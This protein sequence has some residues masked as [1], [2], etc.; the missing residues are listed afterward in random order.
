MS[1]RPRVTYRSTVLGDSEAFFGDFDTWSTRLALEELLD[2]ALDLPEIAGGLKREELRAEEARQA[3]LASVSALAKVRMERERAQRAPGRPPSWDLALEEVGLLAGVGVLVAGYF[4]VLQ[5]AWPAMPLGFQAFGLLGLA[6]VIT[7]SAGR[8][9]RRFPV[10]FVRDKGRLAGTVPHPDLVALGD[11]RD[12]ALREI[13]LPE[14]RAYIQDHRRTFDSTDLTFAEPDPQDEEPGHDLV[15]TAAVRRLRRIVDRADSVAIALAGSRGAGKTTSIRSLEQG[16]LSQAGQAAPL[17]VVGSAPAAYEARDFVLHLHALLCKAVLAAIPPGRTRTADQVRWWTVL[18]R[19]AWRLLSHALK[20]CVAL[21]AVWLLWGGSV[22]QAASE[23]AAFGGDI[24]HGRLTPGQVWSGLPVRR[25]L[26]AGVL[27]AV[28]V[29]ESYGV[30]R[31]LLS[32]LLYLIARWGEAD[33]NRLQRITRQQLD[34]IR[35]LQTYTTGWSGKLSM[36]LRGEAGRTWSTQRAEQQLTHP[37]VVDKFREFAELA[38]ACLAAEDVAGR[39]V[40]A[41]DELDKIGEPE[42][43]HQFINDVKGVFDVPGC[44][45]FVSVSDDA[46]LGFEQRGLGVRDAFDSAF[47]EM[48][49]LE[50]FTLDESRLWVALRLRGISEQFCYLAHCLS[51]GLPR[52]LKRCA[53]E[54]VDL[55]NESYRPSLETVART[56]VTAE[57]AGKTRAF[58]ATAATLERSPELVALTTDLLGVP[59]TEAPGELAGLAARLVRADGEDTAAPISDLRWHSGCFVLFCAT[60]LEIF[61]DTLTGDRL[62]PGLH[63]LA[64]VRRRMAMHPRQAW[65]DLAEFRKERGLT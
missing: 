2:E 60:V 36:P 14:L 55:A 64:V 63:R 38:A 21:V 10:L 22:Q 40:I 24:L 17:V 11:R 4:T 43:A 33:L 65:D 52:D 42:K 35:F 48:V 37:E 19:T 47:S 30:L 49:R 58:T 7:L 56:L 25:L 9:V 61:D 59:G 41:I 50:P 8:I 29:R 46:V 20:V 23:L 54:M 15:H 5:L 12:H 6:C 27:T 51:G 32:P 31:V 3:I 28:L 1:S 62:G 57:L 18:G 13:V 26:A 44:L 53:V 39:V 45:F 16:L 34:R